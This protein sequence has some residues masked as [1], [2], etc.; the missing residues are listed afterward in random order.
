MR[1]KVGDISS[2]PVVTVLLL[3]IRVTVQCHN[4]AVE[5]Y[6]VETKVIFSFQNGLGFT[7]KKRKFRNRDNGQFGNSFLKPSL[8][9]SK[10]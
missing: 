2:W 10:R 4:V 1:V 6:Q 9:S 8:W 7:A 5:F 3:M